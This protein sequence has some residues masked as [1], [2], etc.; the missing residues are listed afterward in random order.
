MKNTIRRA[1]PKASLGNELESAQTT[2]HSKSKTM[3]KSPEAKGSR[4]QRKPGQDAVS[5]EGNGRGELNRKA[6]GR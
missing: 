5:G 1:G 4:P 3:C 6:V 2:K